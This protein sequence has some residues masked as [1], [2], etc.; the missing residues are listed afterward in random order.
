M[1]GGG[2]YQEFARKSAPRKKTAIKNSTVRN[3]KTNSLFLAV[4][5][6]F[7]CGVFWGC[8]FTGK[9]LISNSIKDTVIRFIIL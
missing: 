2:R 7:D 3:R 5:F 4:E 8:T 1:Y 9:L 6:F